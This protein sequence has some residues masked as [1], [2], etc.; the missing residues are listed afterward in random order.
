LE[1]GC[2]EGALIER[3]RVSYPDA[4]IT[5]I[6]LTPRL[7]RLYGGPRE[8]VRFFHC[9]VEDI[10]AAEPG[11][12]DLVALCD[13]LHMTRDEMRTRLSSSFGA[14]ALIAEART[15]P[16]RNNIAMLIRP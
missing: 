9:P 1:V 16:W 10:A 5:G 3:L 8:R 11:L 6:D 13:M 15:A 4:D 12:Y 2:G 14:D 7:G